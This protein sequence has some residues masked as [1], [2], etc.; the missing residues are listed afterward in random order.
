MKTFLVTSTRI[1]FHAMGYEEY[2][3]HGNYENNDI[4][5][6]HNLLDS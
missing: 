3:H 5:D 2:S 1:K 6:N 4:Q